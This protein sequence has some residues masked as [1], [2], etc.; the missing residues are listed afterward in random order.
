MNRY[1]EGNAVHDRVLESRCCPRTFPP[2]FRANAEGQHIAKGCGAGCGALCGGRRRY[3]IH[4]SKW[5][6]AL[7][8]R[9]N[10]VAQV[11]L[12]AADMQGIQASPFC[13]LLTTGRRLPTETTW[14]NQKSRILISFPHNLLVF[15]VVRYSCPMTNSGF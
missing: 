9:K 7:P 13:R 15:L 8:P 11:G 2:I 5:L 1:S 12:P 4:K 3:K 10:Y 14:V 6:K